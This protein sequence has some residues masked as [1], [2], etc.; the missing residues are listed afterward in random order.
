MPKTVFI[1]DLHLD[2]R[3][4]KALSAFLRYLQ[5]LAEQ[6]VDGLYI[7]GD[8]FEYWLGD[9]CLDKNARAVAQGL[10]DYSKQ[11][12]VPVYYI[13]GNRDFLLGEDYAALCQFHILPEVF[14][15]NLYGV[16]TLLLHGDTLCTD[17]LA[18]QQFRDRVR[19]PEWQAKVLKLPRWV[20]RLKAAHLRYRSKQANAQK[21]D[22]IMDVSPATVTDIVRQYDAQRIIH[23]HTHRPAIHHLTLDGRTVWR[24]VVGDWYTQGSVLEVTPDDVQ[25]L[26]LPFST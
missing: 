2:K 16:K 13:H 19:A 6:D 12:G 14:V 25:L 15:I 5:T 3:Y 24:C 10:A 11:T 1:A 8:L 22:D 17:D 18:Y 7:L 21:S 4:P 9:D 20:R 23:G 26:T